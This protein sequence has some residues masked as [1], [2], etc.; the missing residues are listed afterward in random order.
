MTHVHIQYTTWYNSVLLAWASLSLCPLTV[1]RRHV[2]WLMCEPTLTMVAQGQSHLMTSSK[3]SSQFVSSK[4]KKDSKV[5]GKFKKW[6]V[7][8]GPYCFRIVN[9]DNWG[10]SNYNLILGSTD[11]GHSMPRKARFRSQPPWVAACHILLFTR[12]LEPTWILSLLP[13]FS[14]CF[15]HSDMVP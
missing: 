4:I 3:N 10:I 9:Q 2:E 1:S 7:K 5:S 14:P 12:C 13:D 8:S 6:T 15:M 11:R